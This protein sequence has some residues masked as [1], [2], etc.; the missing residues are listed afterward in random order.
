MG[1]VN[2]SKNFQL[3]C[4]GWE[5]LRAKAAA[6]KQLGSI[7]AVEFAP[8]SVLCGPVTGAVQNIGYEKE[9][10]FYLPYLSAAYRAGAGLCVGDGSPDQKLTL[11]LDAVRALQKRAK[12]DAA[13][14][15]AERG[16]KIKSAEDGQLLFAGH[17]ARQSAH[18]L[19]A[20]VFI[21]PYPNGIMAERA[22]WTRDVAG[23]IG[24]DID[25]HHIATMAGRAALE[26]KTAA[27]LKAFRKVLGVPLAV[28]GVFTL[29]D[30]ELIKEL[31]PEICYVSNHGGRI[32]TVIGS[33]ADFLAAHIAEIKDFSGE[34][35]VDGGIRSREDVQTA[36]FYGADKV[37]MAR[38]IISALCKGGEDA[39]F[40]AIKR[41]VS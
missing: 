29:D 17:D 10:D 24:C 18:T 30:I 40:E 4:E 39:A 8:D 28:K 1:G 22:E 21:K 33:T 19:M 13:A 36:I 27:D 3:N 6:G 37:I 14:R 41:V 12:D 5:K 38:P 9:E 34:V 20:A 32:D 11:G 25:A 2:G 35:W 23:I 7:A 31:K 16:E 15:S 26:K